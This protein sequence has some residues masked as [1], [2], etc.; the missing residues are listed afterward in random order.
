MYHI[1][2]INLYVYV[3]VVIRVF[4]KCHKFVE[5]WGQSAELDYRGK[6]CLQHESSLVPCT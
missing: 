4:V 1:L 2:Y 6:R 3:N 5:M